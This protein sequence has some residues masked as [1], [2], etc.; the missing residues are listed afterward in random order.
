MLPFAGSLH[1]VN[2]PFQRQIIYRT[3]TRSRQDRQSLSYQLVANIGEFGMLH[4]PPAVPLGHVSGARIRTRS[5][6]KKRYHIRA[7][8]TGKCRT[9]CPRPICRDQMLRTRGNWM[10]RYF[11]SHRRRFPC[12]LPEK[13]KLYPI[14]DRPV[15]IRRIYN[16]PIP[17][18][19]PVHRQAR[20]PLPIPEA[21]FHQIV[22]SLTGSLQH[23]SVELVPVFL[24]RSRRK[25]PPGQRRT[26]YPRPSVGM[27]GIEHH[28]VR[29]TSN[30][31][32]NLLQK[33]RHTPV[34]RKCADVR[35]TQ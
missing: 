34:I 10:A 25:V 33:A 9:P 17:L 18:R 8:H 7:K 32:S 14:I 3:E 4:R 2:L 11:D 1:N 29:W 12:G 19:T 31:P 20:L 35:S 27:R 5:L 30:R 15:R 22:R 28:V 26:R 13:Q 6:Q 24:Y 16:P 21:P 23:L